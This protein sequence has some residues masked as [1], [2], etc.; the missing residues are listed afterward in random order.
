MVCVVPS[1]GGGGGRVVG[2]GLGVQWAGG[3]R[4]VDLSVLRGRCPAQRLLSG[5]AAVDVSR[6]RDGRPERRRK[7]DEDGRHHPLL[8]G[9]RRHD[10]E[11]DERNEVNVSSNASSTLK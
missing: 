10:A 6:R 8:R 1:V 7:S 3:R 5:R 4:R 2:S 9:R 11:T